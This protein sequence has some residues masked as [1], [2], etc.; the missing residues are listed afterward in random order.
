VAHQRPDAAFAQFGNHIAGV[1]Q[2][3][4]MPVYVEGGVDRDRM[5]RLLWIRG[6]EFASAPRRSPRTES[7]SA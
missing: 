6:L 7:T 4:K 5:L 2:Y 3:N 1:I